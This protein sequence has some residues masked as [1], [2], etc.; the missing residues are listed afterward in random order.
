MCTHAAFKNV[1]LDGIIRQKL[2]ARMKM[3][4]KSAVHSTLAVFLLTMKPTNK[5][6]KLHKE[7]PHSY[8]VL[9]TFE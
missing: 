9:V 8:L 2:I 6:V 4:Y 3:S 5:L 7:L 1:S